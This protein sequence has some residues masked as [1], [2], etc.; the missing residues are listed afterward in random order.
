MKFRILLFVGL[1]GGLGQAQ[2]FFDDEAHNQLRLVRERMSSLE[3]T[4]KRQADTNE[5]Q[6][7]E[8]VDLREQVEAEKLK[9]KALLSQYE[10]LNNVLNS[11]QQ[12]IES[13]H[14]EHKTYIQDLKAQLV[15]L[16][17]KVSPVEKRGVAI[18]ELQARLDKIG[19]QVSSLDVS[20]KQQTDLVR[21]LQ[22][23][24]QE[25]SS[26][27]DQAIQ[28]QIKSMISLQ[29]AADSQSAELRS[30][31][32]LNEDLTNKLQSLDAR[33][34]QFEA[35]LVSE[36]KK[37]S[38]DEQLLIKQ[39]SAEGAALRILI[40]QQS[41]EGAALRS[42]N[43]KLEKDF[44]DAS[45]KL[46]KELSDI[47]KHQSKF[48]GLSERID[49]VETV[50]AL[51]LK[52]QIETQKEELNTLR[53]QN[54]R[55]SDDLQSA[56]KRQKVFYDGMDA[57]LRNFEA[58]VAGP[59]RSAPPAD[60]GGVYE[61]AYAHV[62]AGSHQD[63]IG[64]LEE[65]IK[66]YPGSPRVANARYEVGNAYFALKDYQGALKSYQLLEE[67]YPS[68]PNVPD[69]MLNMAESQQQ[70]KAVNNAKKTLRRVI[71]KFP[72]SKAATQARERLNQ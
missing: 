63:A 38:H 49:H 37:K 13:Q 62:K 51:E 44:L 10:T 43:D 39:Q 7:R 47:K 59:S 23:S 14:T 60:E 52:G 71:A 57:S 46:E 32:G 70:L 8:I 34:H 35:A 15:S 5:Q 20:N 2:A 30:I 27:M 24:S 12:I 17:E 58:I 21:S 67:K 36:V 3:A 40:K 19:E 50:T 41:A 53:D 16:G 29:G 45:E 1:L 55:L 4:S 26:Q 25:S 9:F 33:M 65:F 66:K 64:A 42:R 69:A 61:L 22:A 68:N 72:K 18:Q 56:E 11:T 31:K 28:Q 48:S 54:K 6:G